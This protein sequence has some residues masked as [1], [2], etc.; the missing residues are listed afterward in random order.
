MGAG[1]FNTA[2][3]TVGQ[4]LGQYELNRIKRSPLGLI[5][6]AYQNNQ[7]NQANDQASV[8]SSIASGGNPNPA[9]NTPS[10]VSWSGNPTAPQT[11]TL[12]TLPGSAPPTTANAMNP[13]VPSAPAM[14]SALSPPPPV[15]SAPA[16]TPPVTSAAPMPNYTAPVSPTPMPTSAAMNP[17]VPSAAPSMA[18]SSNSSSSNQNYSYGAAPATPGSYQQGPGI[19]SEANDV[20]NLTGGAISDAIG[21]GV[22]NT[23]MGLA[24]GAIITK[25]T[26]VL[27]GE[28]GAEA[29]V[30]LNNNP[31]NK[32]GTSA[33]GLE[34][35]NGATGYRR[36]RRGV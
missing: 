8:D 23:V 13:N 7:Q 17:N 32:I 20:N 27:L 35:V 9:L 29:V 15:T 24:Q 31:D 4:G 6:K 11:D 12:P 36:N 25:P 14:P 19:L 33:L 3:S 21:G 2:L 16:Y 5:Y 26:K 34:N 22:A 28:K 1:A 18:P 30:P 10:S